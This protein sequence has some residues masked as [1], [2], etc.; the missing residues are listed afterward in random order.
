MSDFYLP[1]LKAVVARLKATAPLTA[2]VGQR[3]YTRVPQNETF[4]YVVVNMS[5]S[6]FST[7]GIVGQEFSVQLDI[8]SRE[9]SPKQN[10]DVRAACFNSLNR[11]DSNLSLDSG[12]VVNVDYSTSDVFIE[13]DGVTFHGILILNIRVMET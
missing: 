5:Q 8:Y 12:G 6:D 13:P 4:P 7:K 2:L 10:G 1:L 11:L 9:A 3:I